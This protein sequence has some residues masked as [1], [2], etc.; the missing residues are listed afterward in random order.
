M[1]G[2][3]RLAAVAVSRAGS[4]FPC[5]VVFDSLSLRA[6]RPRHRW[7]IIAPEVQGGILSPAASTARCQPSIC[8]SPRTLSFLVSPIVALFPA[9][10]H[11]N[12][13][14][15]YSS[16]HVLNSLTPGYRATAYVEFPT[17]AISPGLMFAAKNQPNSC[18]RSI[19]H[20][21]V[22]FRGSCVICHARGGPRRS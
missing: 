10:L 19:L 5:Q 21:S 15:V 14:E 22:S 18:L 16:R 12:L 11:A 9:R 7:R 4:P 2:Y 17:T 3:P 8:L 6:H 20:L 1:F 13:L